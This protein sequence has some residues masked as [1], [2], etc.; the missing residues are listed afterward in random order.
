[1]TAIPV[2]PCTFYSQHTGFRMAF[3]G[4]APH[5][6]SL[7]RFAHD[8]DSFVFSRPFS[9]V[10][11]GVNPAESEGRTEERGATLHSVFMSYLFWGIGIERGK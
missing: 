6:F 9:F 1:M 3:E 5:G 7:L 8:S 10:Y 11:R 2:R 4:F